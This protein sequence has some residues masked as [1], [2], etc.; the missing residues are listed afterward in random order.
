MIDSRFR[1]CGG[2]EFMGA[3]VT[4]R[5]SSGLAVACLDR[6]CMKTA[7]VGGLL[8]SMTRGTRNLRRRVLVRRCLHICVAIHA[9]EHGAVN[10]CFERVRIHVQADLLPVNLGAHRWVAMAG[11]AL[12]VGGFRLTLGKGSGTKQNYQ[13]HKGR[14]VLLSASAART[15]DSE[16]LHECPASQVQPEPGFIVR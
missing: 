2:E 13:K 8:I 7:F 1:V 9:G 11:Q 3:A 4:I 14:Q 5:A 12:V 15:V 6:C 10:G 16:F